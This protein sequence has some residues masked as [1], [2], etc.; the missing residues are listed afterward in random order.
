MAQ[1]E[2]R[3]P[4]PDAV[5]QAV[6]DALDDPRPPFRRVV[7]AN[8]IERVGVWVRALLPWRWWEAIALRVFKV[9]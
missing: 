4:P 2:Q 1:D 8:P 5:A 9:Q 7:V 6:V 3:A